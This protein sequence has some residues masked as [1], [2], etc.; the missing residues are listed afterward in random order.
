MTHYMEAESKK[1]E[2]KFPPFNGRINAELQAYNGRFF[3]QCV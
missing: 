3:V 1:Y 2:L